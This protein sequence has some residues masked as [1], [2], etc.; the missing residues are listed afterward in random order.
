MIKF[1][2]NC[3]HKIT[4]IGFTAEESGIYNCPHCN[5]KWII[6]KEENL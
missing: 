1:C 6:K 3:K 5:T 4:K 2:P